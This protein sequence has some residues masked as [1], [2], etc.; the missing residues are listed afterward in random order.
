MTVVAETDGLEGTAAYG[1]MYGA[2]GLE[3]FD[4]A[5]S[6]RA[7]PCSGEGAMGTVAAMSL[8]GGVVDTPVA[9]G[10][11]VLPEREERLPE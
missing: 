5:E 7:R 3:D 1:S 2:F 9:V 11:A 4:E 10:S 8:F 6:A